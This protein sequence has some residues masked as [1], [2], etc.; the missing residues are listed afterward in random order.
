MI[1][2]IVFILIIALLISPSITGQNP[3]LDQLVKGLQLKYNRLSSLTADFT[4]IYTGRGEK[5]RRESGHV[6]LK[7]PGKMRWDYL[8]PEKKLFVSDGKTIYEYVDS[9]KYATKSSVRE[10]DD[11][12]TPFMFLLG[13][14][15]LRG[16]FK[17]I[18][19]S[20][21]SPVKAGNKVLRMVP[22]RNQDFREII[23]EIIPETLQISRFSLIEDDGDRSDFLFSN[24]R[25]NVPASAGQF[26]FKPP[27]GVEVREND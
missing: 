10:S 7:K 12:R 17:L 1:R 22:K 3:D 25:E 13:R 14:G 18:E 5:S 24:I 23:I 19:F 15:N 4:Q 11:F 21:E 9:E 2:S 20:Q 27:T 16:E 26:T 6:F 8:E